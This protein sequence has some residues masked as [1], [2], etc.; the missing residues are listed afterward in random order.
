MMRRLPLTLRA[1]RERR[2]IRC[3]ACRCG[4]LTIAGSTPRSPPS[5]TRPPAASPARLPAR[6]SCSA[7]SSTPGNGCTS[8]S[9]PGRHRPNRRAPRAANARVRAHSINY[10]ANAMNDP[11]LTPARGDIAARYLEGKVAAARFVDGA[12]FEIG[13]IV[14]PLRERPTSDATLLTQ[15]LRGE[16]IT[17]YDRDGEGFAWGQLN[18]DGYVG[19]IAE[20]ALRAP[21]AAPT[22]KV[23]AIRTFAFPGPSIK[24]PPVESPV[25]GCKL[26]VIREDGAFAVTSEGWHLPRRQLGHL[27]D[28]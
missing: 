8:T 3:G 13:D 4:R 24:L 5:T 20:S 15:A 27:D 14:A 11:R 6:C 12:T 25:L 17:V 22:H 9:T 23:I 16:R 18:D 2:T 1:L 10:W 19:W 21:A 7:S 26:A 28:R